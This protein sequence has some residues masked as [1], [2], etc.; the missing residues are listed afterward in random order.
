M[1]RITNE[2]D[3]IKVYVDKVSGLM[4]DGIIYLED[5]PAALIDSLGPLDPDLGHVPVT[6]TF[7]V[8]V[9]DASSYQGQVM[10]ESVTLWPAS[11]RPIDLKDDV[12]GEICE[13]VDRQIEKLID[14]SDYFADYFAGLA[15]D[16]YDR[17]RD[18]D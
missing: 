13:D 1:K 6:G 5:M 18:G 12:I 10:L 15:D 11:D 4:F 9:E 8:E 14:W 16:A 17:M 7:N 2:I 3:P